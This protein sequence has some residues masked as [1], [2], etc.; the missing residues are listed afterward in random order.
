MILQ[1]KYYDLLKRKYETLQQ[2]HTVLS[3]I[4]YVN[5]VPLFAENYET[6]SVNWRLDL[7]PELVLEIKSGRGMIISGAFPQ[8][9]FDRLHELE[10]WHLTNNHRE[11]SSCSNFDKNIL[12]SYDCFYSHLPEQFE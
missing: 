5:F 7:S 3:Y 6:S 1:A 4:F 12:H 2:G 11:L 9:K 10:S 8:I